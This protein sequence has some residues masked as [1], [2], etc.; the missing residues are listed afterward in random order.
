MYFTCALSAWPW[1]ATQSLTSLGG[2]SYIARSALGRREHRHR[3]R[4]AEAKRA[5]HVGGD[6][7]ALE[8]DRG[9]RELVDDGEKFFMDALQARGHRARATR[10]ESCRAVT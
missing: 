9:G 1:P 8:A 2:Y 10:I 6:E 3:A 5:L 4:L 7:V